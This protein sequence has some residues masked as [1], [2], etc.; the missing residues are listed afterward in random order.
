M[1]KRSQHLL[2][3][4]L[5]FLSSAVYGDHSISSQSISA[6]YDFNMNYVQIYSEDNPW[7]ANPI[8]ITV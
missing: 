4:S 7:K 6:T 5:I 8:V 2:M 1:T 3:S